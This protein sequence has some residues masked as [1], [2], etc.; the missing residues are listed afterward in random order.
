MEKV[1]KKVFAIKDLAKSPQKYCI[2]TVIHLLELEKVTLSQLE[3]MERGKIG[4]MNWDAQQKEE[5]SKIVRVKR[6]NVRRR[7][8]MSWKYAGM[9]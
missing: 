1:E 3:T 9:R 4:Y 2:V 6:L 7:A 8:R 5:E